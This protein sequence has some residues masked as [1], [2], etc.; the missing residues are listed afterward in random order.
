MNSDFTLLIV[1]DDPMVLASLKRTLHRERLT[2]YTCSTGREALTHLD[3]RPVHAALVDYRMP[4]MDGLA[5]LQD[6][7]STYP[8]VMTVILTGHG[9]VTVAVQAMKMGAVDFWEKPISPEALKARLTQLKRIWSLRREN[10]VLKK[11]LGKDK[12]QPELIGQSP[13]IKRLQHLIA[14]V[15][16]SRETVLIQGETGSGK[17]IVAKLIHQASSRSTDPFIPVDCAS[18]TESVFESELFGHA[19][20]AFTGAYSETLG[21]IRSANGGTLFLDEIGE[22]P[23]PVQAKLLRV[24]QEKEVRPV[25]SAKSYPIDVRILAATNRRLED[26]VKSDRFRED[27]FYRLNIITVQIPSLRERKEDIALLADYF[28]NL[29]GD[30]NTDSKHISNEALRC[31]ENYRWPGNVR[32]LENVIRRALVISDSN[33]LTPENLPDHLLREVSL[34]SLSTGNPQNGSLAAY[35]IVAIKK[36]LEKTGGIRKEAAKILNIGE[37]T[38][39]RKIRLYDLK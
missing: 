20:G 26:D 31:L 37:A 15:G 21:L 7:T 8:D 18:I 3:S 13:P 33:H 32:E 14:L 22:L 35:E 38:L 29:H 10:S 24:L 34:P 23:F 4:G 16:P 12:K 11:Q 1:D 28:L 9:N 2:V 5:L 36:A 30:G 6:I 39:Y 25:G 17:E 27:L 19:K